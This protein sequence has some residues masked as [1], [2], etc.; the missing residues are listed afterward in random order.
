MKLNDWMKTQKCKQSYLLHIKGC[1]LA[2]NYFLVKVNIE[3]TDSDTNYFFKLY[4]ILDYLLIRLLSKMSSFSNSK[5]QKSY[6]FL[7][8]YKK[9][10]KHGKITKT[11]K[12]QCVYKV[13]NKFQVCHK[14]NNDW[15]K[16]GQIRFLHLKFK[17]E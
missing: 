10:W 14:G 4:L 3:D 16:T 13:S 7:A 11:E 17:L 1:L 5:C 12:L 8:P 9:G 15:S 6:F 2:K